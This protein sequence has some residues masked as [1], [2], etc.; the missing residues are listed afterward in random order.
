VL[1]LIERIMPSLAPKVKLYEKEF[2]IFEEYGV[3][4][5]IDRALRSKVW[6]RSGGSVCINTHEGL[7]VRASGPRWTAPCAARCAGSRADRSSSTR[8][9]RWS[10]S[11][12]IPAAMWAR[13]PP[14]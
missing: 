4:A 5:E 14:A 9:K 3:Q 8:P 7:G 11:T 2:P 10:R 13:R 1:E 12:S 6:L